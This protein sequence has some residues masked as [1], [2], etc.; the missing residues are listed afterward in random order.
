MV[1]NRQGRPGQSPQSTRLLPIE[2]PPTDAAAL[3]ARLRRTYT[4]RGWAILF[5]GRATW[6]ALHSGIGPI[7]AGTP[8]ELRSAID[9]TAT[10]QTGSS[11]QGRP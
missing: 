4:P 8:L 1:S 10:P 2:E 9:A 3:L 6:T 11:G 7:R 5:D